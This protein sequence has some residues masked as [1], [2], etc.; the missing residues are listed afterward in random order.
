M[1]EVRE[2]GTELFQ[3]GA[4][5]IFANAQRTPIYVVLHFWAI[6]ASGPPS[7][8]MRLSGM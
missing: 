2:V 6:Q 1:P 5:E 7:L 3:E 8:C 4:F